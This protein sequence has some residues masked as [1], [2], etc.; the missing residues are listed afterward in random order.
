MSEYNLL[1]QDPKNVDL[2][3]GSPE[4]LKWRKSHHT[5]SNAPIIM[6]EAPRSWAVDTWEKLRLETAGLG[7]GISPFTQRLFDHGHR[8]EEVAIARLNDEYV[9]EYAPSVWANG[10]YGAS[11]DGLIGGDAWGIEG[12][13][14]LWLEVK[15]PIS[16]NSVMY[17]AVKDLEPGVGMQAVD[18]SFLPRHV[19]WQMVHQAMVLDGIWLYPR[20]EYAGFV[21]QTGGKGFDGKQDIYTCKVLIKD[22]MDHAHRLVRR[23]EDYE[24]GRSQFDT[25]DVEG[26]DALTGEYRK[27]KELADKAQTDLRELRSKAVEATGGEEHRGEG[28]KLMKVQA[29]PRVDWRAVVETIRG[30]HPELTAEV[31]ETIKENSTP[32]KPFFKIILY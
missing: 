15:A 8:M 2:K 22:L 3:Q 18:A 19:F 12:P 1:G 29:K 6:G 9:T 26:W 31:A 13:L 5:A 32:G 28:M 24:E 30:E 7:T 20:G 27:V 17:R 11:V 14:P 21:V 25:G 4:W 16:P 10:K 23:W